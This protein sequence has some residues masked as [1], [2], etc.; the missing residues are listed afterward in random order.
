MSELRCD[1]R[2]K[3]L[4]NMT[5]HLSA[6]EFAGLQQE[7]REGR[8]AISIPRAVARRF[9][10][11][12]AASAIR[13]TTGQGTLLQKAAIW[14]GLLLSPLMLGT[15]CLL[16]AWEFGWLAT[17]AIPVIGIF[18]TIFAGYTSNIGRW[19]PA[20]VL[21]AVAVASLY[22]MP[23]DLSRPLLLFILSLWIH[24]VTYILAEQWLI[25]LVEKSFSAYEMLEE[26]ISIIETTDVERG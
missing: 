10:T 1:P 4:N 16:V 9:F 22:V 24:R 8:S 13:T 26:H 15:C 18:W 21:L 3:V 6:D 12:V 20:T 2:K 11:H 5:T 19:Q 25:R 14:T 17:L 7:F 23:P